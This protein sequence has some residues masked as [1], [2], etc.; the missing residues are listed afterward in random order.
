MFH[1]LCW[2]DWLSSWKKIKLVSYLTH[3][4]KINTRWIKYLNV[5]KEIMKVL[6]IKSKV[7]CIQFRNGETL[8]RLELQKL[9]KK[10]I[11]EYVKIKSFLW[12]RFHLKL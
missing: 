12:Q 11:F 9:C 8:Q 6:A 10:E 2:C 1:K 7:L 3:F 4:T 5:E